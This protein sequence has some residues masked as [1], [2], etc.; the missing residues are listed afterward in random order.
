MALEIPKR[1]EIP[2]PGF[3]YHYKHDPAVGINHYAYEVLGIGFHTEDNCRVEDKV[4]VNYRPLYKGAAVYRASL[5]LGVPCHDFRPLHM[6]MDKNV[7]KDGKVYPHRF[8]RITDPDTILKLELIREE[9]Y[10]RS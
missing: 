10:P 1:S 8:M 7:K 3:Y 2:D 6:F 5:G 4:M 9:L